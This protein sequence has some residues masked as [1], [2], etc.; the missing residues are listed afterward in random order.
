MIVVIDP[1][2]GGKDPGAI[3]KKWGLREADITME[4]ARK[5]YYELK[6]LGASVSM[7]RTRDQTV[8]LDQRCEISNDVKP[9]IFISLHCNSS[10]NKKAHGVEMF[11]SPGRTVADD[12]ADILIDEWQIA[13]PKQILRISSPRAGLKEE[14]FRVLVKTQAPAV[15]IEMGFISNDTEAQELMSSTFQQEAA[16]T[17]ASALL[18]WRREVVK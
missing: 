8:S 17:I 3:N 4:V 11:T 13:F 9:D 10:E 16:E 2:H 12:V 18:K 1:G 6:T 15:L 7:T 14:R 5:L